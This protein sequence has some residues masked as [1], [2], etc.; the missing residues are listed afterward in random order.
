MRRNRENQPRPDRSIDGRGNAVEQL[1]RIFDQNLEQPGQTDDERHADQYQLG[2]EGQRLFLDLR[3]GLDDADQQSDAQGNQQQRR[4]NGQRGQN[5]LSAKI[6]D[7]LMRHPDWAIG[8]RPGVRRWTR[9]ESLASYKAGVVPNLLASYFVVKSL[10]SNALSVEA[11]FAD[12]SPRPVKAFS[13]GVETGRNC[14]TREWQGKC[15]TAGDFGVHNSEV[16][17]VHTVWGHHDV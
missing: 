15:E 17:A 5:G 14:R 1:G 2:Y 10:G 11:I 12:G 4:R 6:D 16:V 3:N 9:T 13:A 8:G 7:Q